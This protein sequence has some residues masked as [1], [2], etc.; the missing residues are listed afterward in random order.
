MACGVDPWLFSIW[1]Q[2]PRDLWVGEHHIFQSNWQLLLKTRAWLAFLGIIL[3][4][5]LFKHWHWELFGVASFHPINGLLSGIPCCDPSVSDQGS[6][7]S[8]FM[9]AVTMKR[10]ND[11]ECTAPLKKQKKRVAELALSLSSTSDDEPPSSVNHAAKGKPASGQRPL[12]IWL[13]ESL[14]PQLGRIQPTA[15][16]GKF[17]KFYR[18]V[19]AVD[20]LFC[21]SP[22]GGWE[23]VITKML[24]F[25]QAYL[26]SVVV[27]QWVALFAAFSQVD[28]V[29][30]LEC[31][32]LSAVSDPGA[33]SQ[34]WTLCC[35]DL[36]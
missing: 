14:M 17:G 18:D 8:G 36:A 29:V 22:V 24:A 27:L 3:R 15:P 31:P 13:L 33:L 6:W 28:I 10:R 30:S 11:S 7:L 16:W 2:W 25:L 26:G 19:S 21:H 9:V 35:G 34:G 32:L 1:H 20:F 23:C 12:T 4:K 5:K